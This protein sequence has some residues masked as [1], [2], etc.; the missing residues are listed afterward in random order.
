MSVE[1]DEPM[2][3][4]PLGLK[5]S[6]E[7]TVGS[8][9]RRARGQLRLLHSGQQKL[10]TLTDDQF[11]RGARL[12][13]EEDQYVLVAPIPDA[14]QADLVGYPRGRTAANGRSV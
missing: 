5:P 10:E 8:I 9:L 2:L 4:V 11:L 13:V 1:P 3:K 6:L 12:V 7:P 14:P